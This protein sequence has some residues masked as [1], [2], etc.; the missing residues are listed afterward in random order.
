MH[1]SPYEFTRLYKTMSRSH[2]EYARFIWKCTTQDTSDPGHFGTSAELSARHCGIC[3]DTS[4]LL[5]QKSLA[6]ENYRAAAS[7]VV[8][9]ITV[10]V[11]LRL[12]SSCIFPANA[13]ILCRPPFSRWFVD[14]LKSTVTARCICVLWS[15]LSHYLLSRVCT[16]QC[17]CSS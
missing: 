6:S 15:L 13:L 3:L 4:A 11:W 17:N 14:C 16:V 1:L 2:V 12:G 8:N 5:Y 10:D 7:N 9:A